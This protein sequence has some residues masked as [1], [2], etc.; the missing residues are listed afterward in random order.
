MGGWS[1]IKTLVASLTILL[2]LRSIFLKMDPSRPLLLI[3]DEVIVRYLS[4]VP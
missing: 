1:E 3:D 4:L 2:Q